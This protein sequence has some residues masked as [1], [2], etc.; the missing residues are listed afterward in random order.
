MKILYAA[1]PWL[2]SS[3]VAERLKANTEHDVR[4]AAFYNK[5][6]TKLDWMLDPV[7]KY[8]RQ[9]IW[10]VEKRLA[11]KK[12]ELKLTS[13]I[14]D[15]N[16]WRPDLIINDYEPATRLVAEVLNI[17][18]WLCS[19]FGLFNF[20]KTEKQL[21]QMMS[22]MQ[23]M[24]KHKWDKKFIYSYVGNIKDD[25]N[26]G[27]FEWIMPDIDNY[28]SNITDGETNIITDIIFAQKPVLVK[29]NYDYL[30]SLYNAYLADDF[31]FGMNIGKNE[32][33][34]D[35][36]ED[37]EFKIPSFNPGKTLAEKIDEYCS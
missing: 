16:H 32:E 2:G 36:V 24:L 28:K 26:I 12:G 17:P 30:D 9:S 5:N 31:K 25:I 6:Y 4:V 13:I 33:F 7:Y 1:G 34:V 3:I 22:S 23:L 8:S 21:P 27:D 10:N 14:D 20:Y 19:S 35:E 29:S 11:Y 18:I 37:R 15:L